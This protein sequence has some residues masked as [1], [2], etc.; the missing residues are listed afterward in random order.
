[1]KHPEIALTRIC[2]PATNMDWVRVYKESFPPEE[3]WPVDMLCADLETG[4]K[5]LHITEN[6]AG[7]TICFTLIAPFEHFIWAD[8]IGVDKEYQ[9]RGIAFQHVSQLLK[10]C[11]SQYP[12]SKGLF[13]ATESLSEPGI[14]ASTLAT[15]SRRQ[16]LW[17]RLGA[18]HTHRRERIYTPNCVDADMPLHIMEL[19]WFELRDPITDN[20]L[21]S[22]ILQVYRDHFRFKTETL[23]NMIKQFQ[24]Q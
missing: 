2:A 24:Q 22:V 18:K 4:K 10:I 7:R 6:S 17:E 20:E 16:N 9:S 23:N 1:M 19:L 15:R 3:L 21:Q 13:F 12:A 5:I 8:Y 14:D 11:R